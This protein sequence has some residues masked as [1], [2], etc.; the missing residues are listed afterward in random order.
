MT[1]DSGS[2]RTGPGDAVTAAASGSVESRVS[3]AGRSTARRSPGEAPAP[4]QRLISR[5]EVPSCIASYSAAGGTCAVSIPGG[6]FTQAAAAEEA[7]SSTT[8]QRGLNA[9][10]SNRRVPALRREGSMKTAA[11]SSAN[12]GADASPRAIETPV[13]AAASNAWA[14]SRSNPAA[15]APVSATARKSPPIP[16]VRSNTGSPGDP[17]RLARRSATAGWVIISRPSAV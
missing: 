11:C 3:P 6:P 15:A 9:A 1:Q 17:S 5:M 16:V 7:S 14:G 13:L 2:N 10:G 8:S 4:N 12:G